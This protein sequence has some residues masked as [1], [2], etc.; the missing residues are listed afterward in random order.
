ME[1]LEFGGRFGAPFMILGLPF[2]VYVLNFA[3]NP[4][5]KK[6]PNLRIY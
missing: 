1:K 6:V 2:A 4:V 5:S 3:C